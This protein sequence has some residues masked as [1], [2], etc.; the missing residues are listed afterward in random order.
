MKKLIIAVL[1]AL[2]FFNA[3]A[4]TSGIHD[5]QPKGGFNLGL[6]FGLPPADDNH[7]DATMPMVSLDGNWTVAS[8]L[9]NAGK[10]GRNGAIDLGFYY[11]MCHYRES[12]NH[13]NGVL[14]NCLLFR[15]AFHFEFVPK[16][17]VYG[18]LFMGTNIW[19]PTGDADWDT[20]TKFCGGPFIGCK[21]YLTQHFGFKAEFGEDMSSD[22]NYPNAA[23][24]FAFKF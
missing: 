18:G 22:H 4:F 16:L 3:N 17:D 9:F 5:V 8:G 10:F 12:A 2:S 13:D 19:S 11:G 14:Q 23:F 1:A 20:D 7:I 15:S 21:Y 24:G 6:Q